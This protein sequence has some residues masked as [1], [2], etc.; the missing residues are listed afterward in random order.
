ML[1]KFAAGIVLAGAIMPA[2]LLGRHAPTTERS[3]PEEA[4]R[5]FENRMT[6]YVDLHQECVRRLRRS[7]VDH[8]SSGGAA[9]QVA[10]GDVIRRA[11]RGAR[12]GDILSP[13]LVPQILRL[14]R[15]DLAT[16]DWRER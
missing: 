12:P 8:V 9:F 3:R 14:L 6:D 16:R 7:G 4:G 1:S 15:A 2:L 10:L 13:A 11:R 5:V